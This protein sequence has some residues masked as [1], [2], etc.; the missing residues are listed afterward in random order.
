MNIL[1]TYAK[2]L[3]LNGSSTF[4]NFTEGYFFIEEKLQVKHS[5][6]IF[7][8]CNWIDKNIGGA[9]NENIDM[10]FSAFKRPNDI[11]LSKK[12]KD[13]AILIQKFKPKK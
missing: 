9:S 10:L 4:G 8:F 7:E 1:P 2:I 5:K 6:E 3:L 13:L 12:A 11:E